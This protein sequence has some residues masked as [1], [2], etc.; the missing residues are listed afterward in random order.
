MSLSECYPIIR[1]EQDDLFGIIIAFSSGVKFSNQVGGYACLHPEIEGVYAPLNNTVVN[2]VGEL[3]AYFTGPKWR[4]WC[5]EGIDEETAD[6]ID[7]VLSQSHYSR[8]LRVDRNRLAD[9]CE[10]WVHV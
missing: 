9:S 5:M 4:G 3:L 1:L 8:R 2:Q 7:S 6:V 10:A